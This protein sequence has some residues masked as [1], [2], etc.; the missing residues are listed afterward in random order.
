MKPLKLEFTAFGSY[1]GT[2]TVDFGTLT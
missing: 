2:E 1:P